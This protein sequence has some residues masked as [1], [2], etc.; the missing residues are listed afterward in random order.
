MM[1]LTDKNTSFFVGD[2]AGRPNDYS[3][4]DRKWA[5]NIGIPFFTPEVGVIFVQLANQRRIQI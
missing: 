4:S 5:L 2:A 1:I 3:S